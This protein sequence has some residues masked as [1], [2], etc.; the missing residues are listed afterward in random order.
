MVGNIS[1]APLSVL[2]VDDE[3]LI[4]WAV[5]EMLALGG[6][7]VVEA[8]SA[9]GALETIAASRDPIDV[10]LLDYRLPDSTNLHLLARI[11]KLLP[12]SAVV[13]MTAYGT[14]EV[15]NEALSLGACRVLAKPFDMNELDSVV[16][17]AYAASQH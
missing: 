10:V 14:S 1:R 9:E 16:R 17:D 6:H 11:R 7:R 3:A 8:G 13:M 4:R 5:A 15:T 2:V 12:G